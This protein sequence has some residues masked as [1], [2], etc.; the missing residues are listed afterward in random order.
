MDNVTS[1]EDLD[2]ALD[3]L[4]YCRR[5]TYP[6]DF[7]EKFYA[8]MESLGEYSHLYILL[9]MGQ[10]QRSLRDRGVVETYQ[11]YIG[12]RDVCMAIAH[13]YFTQTSKPQVKEKEE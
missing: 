3:Y 6:E 13:A 10:I 1:P 8:Y 4:A 11:E 9:Y 7:E 5:C 2:K 12:D